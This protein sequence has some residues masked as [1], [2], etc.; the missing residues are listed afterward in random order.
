M[1]VG[2]DKRIASVDTGM[3]ELS[4][5]HT[6]MSAC[7]FTNPGESIKEILVAENVSLESAPLTSPHVAPC[8][9]RLPLALIALL[10]SWWEVTAAFSR[11]KRAPS[12]FSHPLV[13]GS[14]FFILSLI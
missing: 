11:K 13:P 5:A 3:E 1:P 9:M 10:S 8:L 4:H 2:R 6:H 12:S 14:P 7:L